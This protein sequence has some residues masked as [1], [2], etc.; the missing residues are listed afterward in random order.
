MS[1]LNAA[2]PYGLGLVG[3]A[4]TLGTTLLT[5]RWILGDEAR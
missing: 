4:F 1:W 2:W 5:V 3:L